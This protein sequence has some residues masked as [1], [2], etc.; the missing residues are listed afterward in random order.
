MNRKAKISVS[1]DEKLVEKMREIADKDNRSLSSWMEVNL[2]KAVEA[3][4]AEANN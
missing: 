3:V 1:I 4:E 2:R